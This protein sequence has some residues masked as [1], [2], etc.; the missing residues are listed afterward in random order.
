MARKEKYR[1]N[2][3]CDFSNLSSFGFLFSLF[4]VPAIYTSTET[5]EQFRPKYKWMVVETCK[6][7]S[8]IRYIRFEVTSDYCILT[9]S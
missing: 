6:P 4:N 5:V 2:E 9:G 7:V 1:A 3:K 8:S